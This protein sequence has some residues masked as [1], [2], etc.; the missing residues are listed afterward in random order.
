MISEVDS[1][2]EDV[3][4]NFPAYSLITMP[5]GTVRIGASCEGKRIEF[6]GDSELEVSLQMLKYCKQNNYL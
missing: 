5:N 6:K 2:L 1:S 3:L 4:K